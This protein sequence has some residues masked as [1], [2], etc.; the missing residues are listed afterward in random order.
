MRIAAAGM[1]HQ[2]RLRQHNEDNFLIAERLG[3][4]A[5]ADGVESM[6]CGEVASLMA[7]T[8]MEKILAGLNLDQDATPP[9]DY[10]EGIPLPARAMKFAVREANR[11][12][13]EKAGSE[14]KYNG[15]A[16]TLSA[17]WFQGGRVYV[18][19][20]GDSRAYMARS[21]RMVQLSRDHTVLAQGQAD[22]T[23]SIEFMENYSAATGHELT[24]ALGVNQD[25]EVQL[26]GGSPKPGDIFVLGTDG[27][28]LE[29]RDFE[30]MDTA[31]SYPPDVAVKKLTTMAN[32]RGGKDN[33]A[34]IVIKVM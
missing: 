12:I 21:G 16:T 9:F 27:L 24:R 4:Y 32:D 6:P 26:A 15:M 2:G 17:L 28:Y 3:L 1:K 7:V 30:I 23:V 33:V 10:A 5:V 13:F 11:K 14:A 22:E 20:V 31:N 25:L 18:G 19:N 8:E 34:V 29:I